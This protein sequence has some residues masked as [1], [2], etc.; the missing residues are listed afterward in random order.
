MAG[1]KYHEKGIQW[2]RQRWTWDTINHIVV[3]LNEGGEIASI[4]ADVA[5]DDTLP[6]FPDRLDLR[7]IDF[8]HQN[9]R[10]PW[11]MDGEKR[12]RSGVRLKGADLTGAV[13][14]WAI[15]PR[16]D[17]REVILIDADLTN[18]ELIYSD[19]SQADLTRA[20]LEG[21]WLL[22]TKLHD[23]KITEEQLKSRRNFGQLD[24][25]YHAYEL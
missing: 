11:R 25:D 3:V 16:A 17:L 19:L 4:L 5:Q 2:L 1:P 20:N 10:G 21:A 14:T 15:L 6:G 18:T 24:F 7:G 22:Y 12:D 13:L 23:A 9:L 8:S